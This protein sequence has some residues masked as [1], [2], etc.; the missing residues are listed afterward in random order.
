MTSVPLT[1]TAGA[2]GWLTGLP[3]A[4]KTTVA[5]AAAAVLRERGRLVEV[6][7]IDTGKRR[8]TTGAALLLAE[9]TG[10]TIAAAPVRRRPTEETP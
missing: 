6:L 9:R 8:R 4:G 5:L 1:R 10:D 2:T 7:D 3:S